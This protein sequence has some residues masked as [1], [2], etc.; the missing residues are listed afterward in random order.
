MKINEVIVKPLITEKT[1]NLTKDN[2]FA[3]VVNKK[4]NKQQI[5]LTLEELYSVKIAEVKIV[6]RK[7]KKRLVGKMRKV[8]KLPDTKIAYVKVVKGSLDFFPKA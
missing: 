3:F 1:T 5:K 7:G 4:A 2:F 8:K 6:S